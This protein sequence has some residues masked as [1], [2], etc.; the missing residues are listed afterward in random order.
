MILELG[1]SMKALEDAILVVD[2]HEDIDSLFVEC[3]SEKGM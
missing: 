1:T 3:W 2:D